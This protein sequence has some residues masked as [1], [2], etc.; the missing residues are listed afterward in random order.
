[1][2]VPDIYQ[3]AALPSTLLIGSTPKVAGSNDISH[4]VEGFILVEDWQECL[5]FW[6]IINWTEI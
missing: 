2:W 6:L 3:G 5:L 4:I 1:M